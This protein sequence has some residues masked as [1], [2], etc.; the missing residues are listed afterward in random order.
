MIIRLTHSTGSITVDEI[1]RLSKVTKKITITN[2]QCK[3]I[4]TPTI[5]QQQQAPDWLLWYGF[6]I[7][8]GQY[9]FYRE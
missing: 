7:V 8:L 9:R 3:Q 6:A 4:Q 5:R 1:L 2:I